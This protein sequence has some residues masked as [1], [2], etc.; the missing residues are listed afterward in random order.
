MT[1]LADWQAA[2]TGVIDAGRLD[3]AGLNCLEPVPG[4]SAEQG[5]AVYRNNSRGARAAA[6]ADVYPVCR[7]L[8]GDQS[9]E[10]LTR[11]FVEYAASEQG[12]LNRFGADFAEFVAAT[13]ASQTSFSG[14]PWLGDLVRLEW[15]CHMAYFADD[16]AALDLR[17]LQLADPS[18]FCPR[19][20]SHLGWMHSPWP[21]HLIWRAHKGRVEPS[22]MQVRRGDRYL[23][24][25]RRAFR[26]Q[27][28]VVDAALWALLDACGR[29][30]S[31]GELGSDPGLDVG[32]LGEL[33]KR[34][35]IGALERRDHVV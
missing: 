32:R 24:V 15:L 4:P 20:A 11:R 9:F 21:V 10:G 18:P 23:V 5:F 26:S 12:D 7:R 34:R 2:L 22:P 27:P 13:V 33:V 8:I 35:W 31:L 14:L 25:E 30:M 29:G 19:P 28:E 3:I 17:P 1:A 6:L 16:D